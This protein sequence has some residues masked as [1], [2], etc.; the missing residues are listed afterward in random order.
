ME[1]SKDLILM[2]ILVSSMTALFIKA[3]D[4]LSI[5]KADSLFIN[6]PDSMSFDA[7]KRRELIDELLKTELPGMISTLCS[8]DAQNNDALRDE[9]VQLENE[10]SF[11]FSMVSV[12]FASELIIAV[13]CMKGHSHNMKDREYGIIKAYKLLFTLVLWVAMYF[14]VGSF[15]WR[16]IPSISFPGLF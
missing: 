15:L 10:I 5:K 13:L 9:V 1:K 12:F 8:N 6:S 16:F 11:L 4:S 2:S 7:T 14:G 3:A